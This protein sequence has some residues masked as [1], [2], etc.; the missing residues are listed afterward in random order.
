MGGYNRKD[1]KRALMNLMKTVDTCKRKWETKAI[2]QEYDTF[3]QLK[4]CPNGHGMLLRTADDQLSRRGRWRC[5]IRGCLVD[6]TLRTKVWRSGSGMGIDKIR[7]FI[8]A[9]STDVATIYYGKNQ[10]G[11]SKNTRVLLQTI[12]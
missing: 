11:V 9:W 3:S 8:Y 1:P 10:L 2:F 5:K 4:H 7:M 6:H 12:R